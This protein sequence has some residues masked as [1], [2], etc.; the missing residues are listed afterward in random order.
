MKASTH[1]TMKEKLQVHVDTEVSDAQNGWETG[2]MNW[3]SEE[4]TRQ[5]VVA[6]ACRASSTSR[7]L[8]EPF[9]FIT[10]FSGYLG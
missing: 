1:V 9:A 5:L 7:A 10:H 8:V 4:Q 2:Q 6:A 3:R